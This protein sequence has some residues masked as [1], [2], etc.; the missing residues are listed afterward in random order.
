L[1]KDFLIDP[2]QVLEARVAGADAVLLI[3]EIL[4]DPTLTCLLREV[5]VL[6]MQALVEVHEAD[7]LWRVMRH[8]VRLIGINNRNL[9]TFETNL[10]HTLELARRL[11]S[12]VC[13]V[14]ESGIHAHDDLVRLKAAGVRSVLVGET[15]MRAADMGKQLDELRGRT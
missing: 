10:E 12:H 3:A 11:P 9:K 2:Y 5:R 8:G 7:N 13:L 6:G 14:S 1:R 4:D 15:L